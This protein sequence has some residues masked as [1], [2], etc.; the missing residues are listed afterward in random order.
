MTI[1]AIATGKVASAI[2]IVRL[3]G[4]QSLPCVQAL[5]RPADGKALAAH[6]PRTLVLG[7]LTDADGRVIDHCLA[8]WSRGPHSY[9]GEDTAELQCHGSPAVLSMALEA[10]FAQGARQALPGEFTR[11]AFLNG[12]LD[13]TQA[14]AVADLIDAE[15]AQAA[16]QAAGQLSGA[17][18][19]R[20]AAVY[21]ALTDFS[22]HFHA[23]LDYPDEDIAPFEAAEL[24]A[25]LASAE[26]GWTPCSP[27]TAGAEC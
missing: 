4:P 14:E 20:I 9:T 8:T 15:S 6:P 18:S 17:L 2:G 16:R 25:G 19:R 7:E 11:R 27:P 10:L 24:S 22:A 12:R 26:G 1:A 23:V 5:F 13:L 21:D 3:S